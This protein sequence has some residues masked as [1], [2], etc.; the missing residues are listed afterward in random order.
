MED[1]LIANIITAFRENRTVTDFYIQTGGIYLFSEPV[2]YNSKIARI[3]AFGYVR[4]EI[5]K[6]IFQTEPSNNVNVVPILYPLVLRQDLESESY[7]LIHGSISMSDLLFHGLSPGSLPVEEDQVLDWAVKK[8]DR[9]GALI[10]PDCFPNPNV[11]S[12]LLC[13]SYINLRATPQECL[14][15]LYYEVDD[16][17]DLEDVNFPVNQFNEV[18]VRLNLE[19]TLVPQ[20]T[21]LCDCVMC[22][23]VAKAIAGI[24]GHLS[25][26]LGVT[27]SRCILSAVCIIQ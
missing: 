12:Q 23:M 19:A 18:H 6:W 2:P 25:V 13:P 3:R 26:R 20:G 1:A 11:P 9:I 15:A 24:A 4:D 27:N 16:M 7:Q 22:N 5:L 21:L 14:S 17:E 8:G 10:P